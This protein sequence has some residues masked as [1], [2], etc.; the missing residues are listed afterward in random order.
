MGWASSRQTGCKSLPFSTI[1]SVGKA[2]ILT[3]GITLGPIA[4]L[5]FANNG[6]E[7]P[8]TASSRFTCEIQEGEYTVMYR[9][10]SAPGQAYPWAVPTEMGGGWTPELRCETISARLEEYRPDGLVELRIDIEN[11]YN[12]VCATTDENLD[13]CR[14]VFT[15]PVGQ[16]PVTTRDAVFSNI[17]LA[18]AGTD[19]SA[20][21]TFVG[22]TRLPGTDLFGTSILTNETLGTLNEILGTEQPR[23][24]YLKPYLD[25]ADGGTGRYLNHTR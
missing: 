24:I 15:V 2:S 20:V 1:L 5:A 18:D 8:E 21:N 3:L 4:G 6:E 23:G 17:T 19:T 7:T 25:P 14:I 9:P 13:A 16:D 10:K 22:S 12:T 11:G